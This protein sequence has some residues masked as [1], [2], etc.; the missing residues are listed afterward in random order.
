MPD[1][2]ILSYSSIQIAEKSVIGTGEQ[3]VIIC[4][5]LIIERGLVKGLAAGRHHEYLCGLLL[6][7]A[8]V[9]TVNSI[10]H[11]G[12]LFIAAVKTGLVCRGGGR[13]S[14][15]HDG[16]EIFIIIAVVAVCVTPVELPF[17]RIT[18]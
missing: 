13:G 2:I 11:L 5:D 12:E 17:H 16:D 9:I 6:A 1:G 8:L 3:A 7:D 15:A 10:L 18:E 14:R 4:L